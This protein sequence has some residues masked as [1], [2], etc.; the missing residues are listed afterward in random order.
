MNQVT[1]GRVLKHNNSQYGFKLSFLSIDD[2]RQIKDEISQFL[3]KKYIV[4]ERNGP[5]EQ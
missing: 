4:I 3:E 2:A 5:L 1:V